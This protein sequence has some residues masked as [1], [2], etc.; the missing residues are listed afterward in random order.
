MLREEE[1]KKIV[2][3][4]ISRDDLFVENMDIFVC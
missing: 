1:E 2:F 4:S 3:V